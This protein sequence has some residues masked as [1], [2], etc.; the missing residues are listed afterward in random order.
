MTNYIF[1]GFLAIWVIGMIIAFVIGMHGDIKNNKDT[2]PLNMRY[3]K[4]QFIFGVIELIGGIVVLIID[5]FSGNGYIAIWCFAS[6]TTMLISAY[7]QLY[8][9]NKKNKK[10][11]KNNLEAKLDEA[12]SQA[13]TDSTRYTHYEV[14][15]SIKKK[16]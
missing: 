15:S 12:D 5:D 9:E 7:T 13:K 8:K 16:Q 1:L 11:N 10:D 6:G 14:F 2:S 3:V 4:N